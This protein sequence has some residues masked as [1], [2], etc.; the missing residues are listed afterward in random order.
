MVVLVVVVV[1]GLNESEHTQS[2]RL[3]R[4]IRLFSKVEGG[5]GGGERQVTKLSSSM[6][7]TETGCV[8]HPPIR[9]RAGKR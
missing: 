6:S 8:K 2:Y 3:S 4:I 7:T 9:Q 1:V 5:G